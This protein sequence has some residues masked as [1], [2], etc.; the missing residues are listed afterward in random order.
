MTLVCLTIVEA[1]S[2]LNYLVDALV[3]HNLF[4]SC[5][6]KA[7]VAQGNIELTSIL[8]LCSPCYTPQILPRSKNFFGKSTVFAR[9][10]S[11]ASVFC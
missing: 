9:M 1:M 5:F 6:I 8:E 7:T 3:I 4:F 10:Y 11:I 2:R